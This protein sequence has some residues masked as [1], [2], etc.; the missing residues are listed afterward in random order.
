MWP[1]TADNEKNTKWVRD[2]YAATSP[3]AMEAGYVN[4]MSGDDSGR[5]EANYGDNYGR[6]VDIKSKYD[7][8]NV[9]HLNQN[10]KPR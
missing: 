3:F 6:L 5:I 1:D 2:Y 4:F 8:D 9:F 7:P 10:I